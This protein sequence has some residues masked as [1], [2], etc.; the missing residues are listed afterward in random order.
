MNGAECWQAKGSRER[1]GDEKKGE[2]VSHGRDSCGFDEAKLAGRPEP[3]LN[4][5]EFLLQLAVRNE[6]AP[7]RKAGPICHE[8]Q[9]AAEQ[10]QTISQGSREDLLPVSLSRAR[11]SRRHWEVSTTA[12]T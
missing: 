1:A 2:H 12:P 5:Q 10:D 3:S 6:K 11:F 8:R 9:F 4:L 7:P